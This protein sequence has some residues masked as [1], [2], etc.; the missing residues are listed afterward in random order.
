MATRSLLHIKH[1]DEF[2]EWLK[3]DGFTIEEPKGEYEVIRARKGK[4]ILLVYERLE[5]KEHFTVRGCDMKIVGAFFK[6]RNMRRKA[7]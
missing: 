3:K 1:K 4:R 5:M 6:E 2:I 7:G